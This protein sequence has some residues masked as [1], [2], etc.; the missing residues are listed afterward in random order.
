MVSAYAT[1]MADRYLS[2]RQKLAIM[3]P[4]VG[5]DIPK[6]FGK[7]YG[8]HA[9]EALALTMILDLIRDIC[10]FVLDKDHRAPS[11]VNIWR[12]MQDKHLHAPAR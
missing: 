11:L 7:S 3:E 8:A 9:Q 6:L 12:L 2:A 1:V 10:A 5:G 4:F